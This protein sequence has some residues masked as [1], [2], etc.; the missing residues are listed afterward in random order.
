MKR[1]I[2]QYYYMT[3]SQL[4]LNQSIGG[5]DLD[6]IKGMEDDICRLV[7]G[8]EVETDTLGVVF[9]LERDD[10]PAVASPGISLVGGG[11]AVPVVTAAVVGTDEG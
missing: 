10:L 6:V 7:F 3:N 8:I 5:M 11:E 4:S 2:R 9:V 1:S